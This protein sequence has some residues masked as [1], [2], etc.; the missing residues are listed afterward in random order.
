MIELGGNI[1]LEGFEDVEPRQMIIV[2][3]VIGTFARKFS[4][5]IEGFEGIS[6]HLKKGDKFEVTAKL[7]VK[8]EAK[9]SKAEDANLFFAMSGAL[10]SLPK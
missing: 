10:N 9:E 8:G 3:K 4:D 7:T 1:K 5:T 2:R 6:I